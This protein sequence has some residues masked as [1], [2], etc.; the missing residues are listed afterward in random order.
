V[1]AASGPVVVTTAGGAGASTTSFVVLPAAPV[2]GALLPASGVPGSV[3]TVTGSGLAGA[4]GVAFNGAPAAF[5]VVSPA[6]I[7]A[8]VP[9]AATS[10]PVTVTTPGGTATSQSGFTLIPRATAALTFKVQPAIVGLGG[11]VK[12][13]GLLTPV[14]LG[15]DPVKLSVQ[16]RSGGAWASV[17]T[18]TATT[19]A[20]GAYAWTYKPRRRGSYR[21]RASVVATLSHTAAQ[22]PWRAFAV[23]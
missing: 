10:G 22:T 2:V 7:T 14:S 16:R 4:T 15:G 18:V 3:V 1:S 6:A 12:G 21:I 13:S 8:T 11:S 5:S 17:K 19:K 9:V 20:T 23:K